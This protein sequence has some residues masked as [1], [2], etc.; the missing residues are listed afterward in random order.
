MIYEISMWDDKDLIYPVV[1][2]EVEGHFTE[3]ELSILKEIGVPEWVAPNM[4]FY[5]KTLIKGDSLV[6]CEDR[7]DHQIGVNLTS[8]KIESATAEQQFIN[9]S[10]LQFMDSIYLF[11]EMIELALKEDENAL[12]NCQISNRLVH[13]FCLSLKNCDSPASSKNS[14]WVEQAERVEKKISDPS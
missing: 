9:S 7:N 13:Q 6:F 4:M 2:T 3:Q 5:E 8:G 10:F 1:P 12:V 14:F 11:A